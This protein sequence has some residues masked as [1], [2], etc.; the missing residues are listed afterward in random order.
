[1]AKHHPPTYLSNR[2]WRVGLRSERIAQ[3][4]TPNPAHLPQLPHQWVLHRGELGGDHGAVG[5]T[6]T[7]AGLG[8]QRR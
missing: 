6:V 1:M 4:T 7:V 5:V 3:L 2:R 8:E